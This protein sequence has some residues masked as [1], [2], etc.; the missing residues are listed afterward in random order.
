MKKLLLLLLATAANAVTLPL[1]IETD[2]QTVV[3]P[4]APTTLAGYGITDVIAPSTA[5][6]NFLVGDGDGGWVE[7]S[8]FTAQTSI[9]IV[10]ANGGVEIGIFSSSE[11]GVAIGSTSTATTGGAVGT[12]ASTTTGGAVGS[13]AST[14]TGGAVG[15]AA[16]TTTGGAVGNLAESTDG[17]AGGNQALAIGTGRVQLGTGIN[18]TDSTIQF[19]SSGSVTAAEFG[20]L[21]SNVTT[22]TATTY[23][24]LVTDGAI[25]VS[26]AAGVAITLPAAASVPSNYRLSIVNI[27]ASGAITVDGDSTETINGELTIILTTQYESVTIVAD[28]SN[29]FIL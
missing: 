9:Q 12:A 10:N 20:R 1:Y 26:N 27:G 24:A 19:L 15:T 22:V 13:I 28:G 6:G 5:D 2:T 14:T 16:S 23:T 7:E 8:G 25:L 11:S 21:A 29:W 3:S 17:F 4:H 18:N